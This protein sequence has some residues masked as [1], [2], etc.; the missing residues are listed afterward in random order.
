MYYANPTISAYS[1]SIERCKTHWLNVTVHCKLKGKTAASQ[2]LSRR[3]IVKAMH[4][5][6]SA[7]SEEVN[8]GKPLRRLACWGGSAI[9][10]TP[11]HIHM[12]LEKPTQYSIDFKDKFEE[13]FKRS[14]RDV[15][16]KRD[17]E[18]SI[19]HEDFIISEEK[20]VEHFVAYILRQENTLHGVDES[21]IILDLLLLN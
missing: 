15:L 20:K 16:N 4:L 18:P 5:T 2:Y 12:V 11:Q 17:I 9:R 8:E 3:P 14:L 7:L 1:K 21:K 19:W 6:L 10:K 13:Y